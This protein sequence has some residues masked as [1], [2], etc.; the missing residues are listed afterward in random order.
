MHYAFFLQED[1]DSNSIYRPAVLSPILIQGLV[2]T[3]IESSLPQSFFVENRL[4]QLRP[5][6]VGVEV[7]AQ[8]EVISSVSSATDMKGNMDGFNNITRSSGK[9]LVLGTSVRRVSDGALI[10]EGEQVVWLPDYVTD[11]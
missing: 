11:I 10:A 7:E 8:F 3:L 2:G 4:K 9:E 1:L 5:L 6:I